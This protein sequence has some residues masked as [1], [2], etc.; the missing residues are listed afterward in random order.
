MS[1]CRRHHLS[2]DLE[3]RRTDGID[4]LVSDRFRKA[5]RLKQLEKSAELLQL[6]AEAFKSV[7]VPTR[8]VVPVR[9]KD[10]L[11]MDA[12]LRRL[13]LHPPTTTM[14]CNFRKT[15]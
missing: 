7:L 13:A 15:S 4:G 2:V 11:L 5:T 14:A 6:P 1:N 12:A 9:A 3:P 10:P 8:G